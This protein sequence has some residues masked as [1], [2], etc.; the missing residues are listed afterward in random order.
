MFR[1]G[2]VCS[3]IEAASVAFAPLGWKAA[4]FSEIEPFPCTVLAHHYP[5]V[6]NLGDMRALP[7]LIASGEI[8]AAD[9]LVGGTPCQGF[10]LA[11]L[12]G[13]LGDDR[14]NLCLTFCEI[15]DAMDAARTVQGR[16]PSIIVWENVDGCLSTDDNAF[17]C[18]IGRLAGDDTALEPGERPVAGKE[19][20]CWKWNKK[21]GEH[22][23]KWPVA[24]AVVGPKRVVAWRVFDAEYFG[25]AQRRYRVFV[26]ASARK[27]FDPASVL[28][29]EQGVPRH[30]PPSREAW[31]EITHDV[32]SCLDVS[33]AGFSR[34]GDTRGQDPVIAV[35]QPYAVANCLTERMHKGI[36]STLDEGQTPVLA[37]V[38]GGPSVAATIDASYGRLQGCSGQDLGHSHSTL[39][40]TP[41]RAQSQ[42]AHDATLET[43]V[44]HAL[45]GEGH[46]ASED[47]TGRGTPIVPVAY[48]VHG[49]NSVAM[50]GGGKANV[51]DAVA[52][53]RALDTN[54][55][56]TL[57]QGGNVVLQ[58]VAFAIQAGAL[59][60][61]VDT[62]PDGVGCREGVA[63]TIEARSEVQVVAFSCKDHGADAGDVSPTLRGMCHDGS[64]ANG[65]G[66]VAI[67]FHPL[68]D[69]ISS[70]DGTTHAVGTGCKAG[71][72]T[73][74][75]AFQTRIGRCDRGQPEDICPALT[76]ADAGATSD[77]R[78]CVAFRACG[79]EGFVPSEASPPICASDGGGSGVPSVA[80]QV[81]QSG[82]RVSATHATLDANN[83]PRRHNGAVVPMDTG[84]AVRRLTPTECEILQGFPPGYTLIRTSK[85]L[86]AEDDY[87][88]Y[89]ERMRPGIT[90][91]EAER[92]AKDAPR[93]KALGN[94]WAV[95]VVTWI[96]RRIVA[97]LC[98]K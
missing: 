63:Y 84:W 7:E 9:G 89:L 51:A 45:T 83:G 39:V 76:G 17:G 86:K 52:V 10:S 36:N 21:T 40:S 50:Q 35:E 96:G 34:D 44:A 27:G 65:G 73:V 69:P 16:E 95:T 49:E 74:A 75:I 71:Q 77:S 91:D 79:Q 32:A 43:Y 12:R 81:S 31:E 70:E 29:V 82:V 64:H 4:W 59:R 37:L 54:G 14:S 15:A 38:Q 47:G 19:T 55:G 8:E 48:R 20:T 30:S 62:G 24:G 78:T 67:A 18:F 90:R 5:D 33:G 72:A 68:Q 58:P 2:S 6:K 53:T 94:S 41:L 88:A 11:G 25:L 42:S 85:R 92:L 80:F 56:F 46:D 97:E 66:Q 13:S 57:Q 93:Y 22:R 23:A 1:F 98:R 60:E 3:G 87:V 26:V 28:L 61:N